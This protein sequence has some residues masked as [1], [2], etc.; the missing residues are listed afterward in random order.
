[1][2]GSF[3]FSEVMSFSPPESVVHFTSIHALV[4]QVF[5]LDLKHP[6]RCRHIVLKITGKQTATSTSVSELEIFNAT[7]TLQ[8]SVGTCRCVP[9]SC[10]R[11]N[12][13]TRAPK[14]QKVWA[15]QAS[16]SFSKVSRTKISPFLL[17]MHFGG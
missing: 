12:G 11:P 5:L 10:G 9:F 1:V 7:R 3:A 17:P 13:W 6:K 4:F 14:L 16:E 8:C 15:G 2:H